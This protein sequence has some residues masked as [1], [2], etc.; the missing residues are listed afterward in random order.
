[1][2]NLSQFIN[3]LRGHEYVVL[4]TETTGMTDG[5][6]VQI[7]IVRHTGEIAYFSH[8]KPKHPIPA[9]ATAI[10][11][12]TDAQVVDSP[13]WEY[14]SALIEPI[15]TGTKVVAYNA[16]YDRKMMH[17]SAEKS[18]LTKVDWKVLSPWYCCMEAFAEYFGD[19]SK[20]YGSYKWQKLSVAARYCA[21]PQEKE[22]SS[23]GDA[24]TTRG[25][26]EYLLNHFWLESV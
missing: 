11:G 21:I 5:E 3:G 26:T 6:I 16:V 17:Q 4:D 12:I 13:P 25:V 24:I 15:L 14:V 19:Y 18:G 10:H 20:W 2:N 8:V 7:A 9:E 22:H 23:L 1:M